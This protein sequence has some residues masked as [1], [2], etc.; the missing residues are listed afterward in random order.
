MVSVTLIC[1]VAIACESQHPSQKMSSTLSQPPVLDNRSSELAVNLKNSESIFEYVVRLAQNRVSESYIN[2]SFKLPDVLERLNYDQYRAIRFKSE[3]SLWKGESSFEVQLFHPGFVHKRLVRVNLISENNIQRLPFDQ[4]FFTYDLPAIP[5]S[6]GSY[7]DLDYAGFR[8]HY[9]INDLSVQD[10]V[11]VFLGAS[12]FRLLGRGHVY[13][14][15]SRGLAIDTGLNRA[16][17]FPHFTEFWL[18]QP[19]V[20]SSEI[21]FYAALDSPSVTGAYQFVLKP[22]ARTV[23]DVDARLFARKNVDKIGFAPMSSM[24]LYGQNRSPWFDDFRPQVHDSDGL[25]IHTAGNNW[26]WRPLRN[27]PGVNVTSFSGP[28]PKG[29]GLLQRQRTFDSYLDVEAKYHKRPS[30]W[31]IPRKGDW[32]NGHIELLEYS[33]VSEFNDNIAA[34]WVPDEPFRAGESRQYSYSIRM[35]DDR[36]PEQ[37]V[38]RV[39]NM[40]IGWDTLPGSPESPSKSQRRFVIDFSDDHSTFEKSAASAQGIVEVSSGHVSDLVVHPLS[41]VHGWRASFRFVPTNNQQAEISL[42]LVSDQRRRLTETWNY[43]WDH[44]Q[45]HE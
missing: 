18:V 33:T 22:G 1:F 36:L 12:Y 27:G 24:F 7:P 28:L 43:T 23:L 17:E 5:L 38:A 35:F 2:D 41:D 4:K 14:L 44:S 3:M 40:R 30:E 6:S 10:E 26:I 45:V 31:I 11:I 15:S 20:D 32:G 19:E 16:E 21:T 34:Y 25:L 42:Y 37:D 8:V 39:K 13:G 9:P 29:F